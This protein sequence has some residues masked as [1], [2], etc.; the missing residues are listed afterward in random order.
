M[1]WAADVSGHLVGLKLR[2]P[3]MEY[4][5]AWRLALRAHPARGR[6]AGA[7]TPRLFEEDGSRS[8]TVVAF[9]RRVCEHAWLNVVGVPG[10]GDGPSLRFFRV[11]LL[12]D[13]DESTRAVKR[14]GARQSRLAA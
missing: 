8:D 6:D 9:T 4:E 2:H 5:E 1:S 13:M 10:S 11:E 14:T 3:G 7:A 12:R